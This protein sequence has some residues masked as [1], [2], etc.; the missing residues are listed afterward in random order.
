MTKQHYV[1][2]VER[3]P[4]DSFGVFFPDLPGCVSAG[5]TLEDAIHGARE[6]LGLHAEGMAADGVP[7]PPPSSVHAFGEEDFPGVE[8]ETLVLVPVET[9][10]AERETP[11]RINVSLLPSLISRLDAAAEAHG[12]TRSGLLSTAARQWLAANR[13]EPTFQKEVR[14]SLKPSREGFAR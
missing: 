5:A 1:A 9:A 3:G 14:S 11:T 4:D 10:N 8:V 13:A 7:L 2:V 6:A 12:L